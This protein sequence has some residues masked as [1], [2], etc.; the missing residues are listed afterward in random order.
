MNNDDLYFDGKYR[1]PSSRLKGWDY[2]NP[3]LYFI[4]IC[5]KNKIPFFG[6]VEKGVM[7]L[8]DLGKFAYDYMQGIST[9]K[10]DADLII[11]VVMPNHVHAIIK[12]KGKIS[13]KKINKFGPLIPGSLSALV[14]HYKGRVTTY[15]NKNGL[16]WNG[17]QD[18]FHDH[19]IRGHSQYEKIC[20]YIATNPSNWKS[21]RYYFH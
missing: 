2:R 13:E 7:R 5:T 10:D 1:I 6:H 18:L 3:F 17:W 16:P 19:I 4:T 11:H 9:H 14:N 21:D 8:N 20:D 15:A 12:L